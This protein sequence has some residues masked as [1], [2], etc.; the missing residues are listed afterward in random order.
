MARKRDRALDAT[1]NALSGEV[2]ALFDKV[3]KECG[4]QMAID[5]FELVVE[6]GRESEKPQRQHLDAWTNLQYPTMEEAEAA[7]RRQ[8]CI[9]YAKLREPNAKNEK[10]IFARIKERYLKFNGASEAIME[11]IAKLKPPPPRK[12]K[13]AHIGE[14]ERADLLAFFDESNPNSQW[15]LAK[16]GLLRI[17]GQTPRRLTKLEFAELLVSNKGAAGYGQ[18]AEQILR[19]LKYYRQQNRTK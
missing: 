7:D 12:K 19:K 11:E 6:A 8:I 1:T 13:G 10:A 18:S 15:C 14:Q 2:W 17:E 16:R 3:R 4:S 5:V 9:W